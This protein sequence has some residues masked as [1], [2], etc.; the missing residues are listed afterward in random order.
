MLFTINNII[1]LD[2]HNGK[3]LKSVKLLNGARS[4]QVLFLVGCTGYW[5][6]DADEVRSR[7]EICIATA[8]GDLHRH[9]ALLVV[10]G[11]E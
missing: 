10:D 5:Q 3:K 6:N 2:G 9:F 11:V 1:D 7:D 8:V 4:H